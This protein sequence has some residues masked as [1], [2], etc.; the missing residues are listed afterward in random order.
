[1]ITPAEAFGIDQCIQLMGHKHPTAVFLAN[2]IASVTPKEGTGV[3][4]QTGIDMAVKLCI[5]KGIAYPNQA[6]L[7]FLFTRGDE[8]KP[9]KRKRK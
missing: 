6:N 7:K 2:E 4:T 5:D 1:M 9:L 8:R 3:E